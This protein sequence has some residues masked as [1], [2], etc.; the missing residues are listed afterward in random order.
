[1]I[2][3][4]RSVFTL[5]TSH[6][7]RVAAASAV[8]LATLARTQTALQGGHDHGHDD[9]HKSSEVPFEISESVV[10]EQCPKAARERRIKLWT[11]SAITTIGFGYAMSKLY[12]Y[13]LSRGASSR[14]VGP[15]LAITSAFSILIG[16][17]LGNDL[18]VNEIAVNRDLSTMSVRTGVFSDKLHIVSLKDVRPAHFSQDHG[19]TAKVNGKSKSFIL[20]DDNLLETLGLKVTHRQLYHDL[21]TG[22]FEAI[23]KYHFKA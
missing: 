12:K 21:T 13:A 18:V 2:G 17:N 1:M 19:F 23:K 16:F 9:H 4:M 5:R 11:T 15:G 10:L 22:N 8:A 6:G 3:L 14:I 20:P 7:R